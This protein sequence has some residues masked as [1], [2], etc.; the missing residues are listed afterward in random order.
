MK[1][2]I[3]EIICGIALLILGLF[4]IVSL[5]ADSLIVV[6]VKIAG[7]IVLLPLCVTTC[8]EIYNLIRDNHGRN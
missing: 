2:Q 3:S 5:W 4:L 8:F 1:E 7:T 6:A